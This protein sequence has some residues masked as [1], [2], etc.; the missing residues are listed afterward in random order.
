MKGEKAMVALLPC[1]NCRAEAKRYNEGLEEEKCEFL[2]GS[3]PKFDICCTE[4]PLG[5]FA[6]DSITNEELVEMWNN[7]PR[8]PSPDDEPN[9]D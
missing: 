5:L 2:P 8:R 1:P 6:D 9:G 4:C 3:T 7:L